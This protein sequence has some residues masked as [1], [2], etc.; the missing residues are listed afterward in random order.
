MIHITDTN[1]VA[2]N[3]KDLP[4]SQHFYGEVLGMT[5]AERPKTFKFPG[6][7]YRMGTAE[8]HLIVDPGARPAFA[9]IK[10][11]DV[12][13]VWH[14]AFTI[15]DVEGTVAHLN[16]HGVEIVVGPRPRGDGAIQFYVYDPDGYLVEFT[17]RP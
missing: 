10:D 4:A 16:A 11:T 9:P 12:T 5:E 17:T 15:D 3:V 13:R 1:H 8:M 14:L 7:W 2:L 6:A